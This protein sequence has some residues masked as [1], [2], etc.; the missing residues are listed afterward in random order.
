MIKCGL[1]LWPNGHTHIIQH[2]YKKAQQTEFMLG[3]QSWQINDLW[4]N[5]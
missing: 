1:D 5:S 2:S 4:S 3:S